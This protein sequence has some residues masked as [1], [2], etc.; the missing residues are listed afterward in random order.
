M[1]RE[2]GTHETHGTPL[3]KI[4]ARFGCPPKEDDVAD[5]SPGQNP[6]PAQEERTVEVRGEEV[7][8]VPEMADSQVAGQD[9]AMREQ[10]TLVAFRP[11][12]QEPWD[13]QQAERL[14]AELKQHIA[15]HWPPEQLRK[16][17]EERCSY[18]W[19][20]PDRDHDQVF[21]NAMRTCF[22][23]LDDRVQAQDMAEV[24]DT[25]R[26]INEVCHRWSRS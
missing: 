6:T 2:H 25:I 17:V 23:I 9:F 5:V 22:D 12:P 21:Q 14:I 20:T 4:L 13:Q 3:G 19:V 26:W 8:A 16:H 24:R 18:P 11:L 15:I 10:V 7:V 1:D